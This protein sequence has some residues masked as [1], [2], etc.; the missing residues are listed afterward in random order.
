MNCISGNNTRIQASFTDF[1]GSPVDAN[2]IKLIV[3]DQNYKKINEYSI[4]NKKN[5]G[6]YYIDYI[7]E[8]ITRPT[9]YYIEISGEIG[10][11]VTLMRDT[12]NVKFI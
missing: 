10:G 1:D 7:P 2:N 4:N 12:L 11:S 3:Y 8:R 6:V 9:T 5:I